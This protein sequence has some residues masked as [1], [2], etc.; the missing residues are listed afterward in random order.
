[1]HAVVRC[2]L[3]LIFVVGRRVEFS[4]ANCS[5]M[6]RCFVGEMVFLTTIEFFGLSEHL[7]FF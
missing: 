1:M 2:C 5:L 7:L 4:I 3:C 6:A